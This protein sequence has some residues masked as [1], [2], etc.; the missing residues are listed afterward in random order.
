MTWELYEVWGLDETSHEELLETTSSKK[1]AFEI[2]KDSLDLGYLE[3]IVYQENEEGDMKEL[4]RFK[5]G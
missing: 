1:Q 2:A 3:I 4:E 5:H